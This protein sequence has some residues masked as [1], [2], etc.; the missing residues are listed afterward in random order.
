MFFR[1]LCRLVPV[2]C[3]EKNHQDSSGFINGMSHSANGTFVVSSSPSFDAMPL[4]GI[5]WSA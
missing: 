2:S 3:Y 4:V 5:A 1:I